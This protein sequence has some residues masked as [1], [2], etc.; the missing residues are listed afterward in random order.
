MIDSLITKAAQNQEAILALIS[1]IFFTVYFNINEAVPG[2]FFRGRKNMVN[3]YPLKIT[4]VKPMQT[5]YRNLQR[6]PMSKKL[7][8]FHTANSCYLKLIGWWMKANANSSLRL[9]MKKLEL[10]TGSKKNTEAIQA[11]FN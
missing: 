6:L 2:Q 9:K 3:K 10:N 4:K 8:L 1:F 5:S 11:S 7:E